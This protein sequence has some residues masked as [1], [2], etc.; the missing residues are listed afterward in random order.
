MSREKIYKMD[1]GS[2]LT[3]DKKEGV[4]RDKMNFDAPSWKGREDRIT[5]RIVKKSDTESMKA[6]T[7]KQKGIKITVGWSSLYLV[8]ISRSLLLPTPLLSMPLLRVR[9]I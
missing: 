3:S 1:D 9:K 4:G 8:E 2:W 6:I 5:I 7:F